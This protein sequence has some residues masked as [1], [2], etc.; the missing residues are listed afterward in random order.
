MRAPA[1]WPSPS[2]A[3]RAYGG[4]DSSAA[5]SCSGAAFLTLWLARP[6]AVSHLTVAASWAVVRTTGAP[7]DERRAALVLVSHWCSAS[8]TTVVPSEKDTR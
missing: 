7:A 2:Q 8:A 4:T 6:S 5:G 3:P 1:E